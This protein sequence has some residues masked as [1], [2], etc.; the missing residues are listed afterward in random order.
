MKFVARNA[1]L[2][3]SSYLEDEAVDR[4]IIPRELKLEYNL[5]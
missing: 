4:R 1:N 5:V 2:M 3:E